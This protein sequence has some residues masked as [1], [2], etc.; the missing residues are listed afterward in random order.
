MREWCT[1]D[2]EWVLVLKGAGAMST[3][4]VLDMNGCGLVQCKEEGKSNLKFMWR[5]GIKRTSGPL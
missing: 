5:C 2:D 4:L 1:E 3:Q